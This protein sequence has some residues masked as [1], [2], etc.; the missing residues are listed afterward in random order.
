MKFTFK[1]GV[2][3]LASL[4]T[5]VAAINSSVRAEN[6]RVN[7]VPLPLAT[8]LDCN[9]VFIKEFTQVPVIKNSTQTT[10]PAGKVISWRGYW[11]GK[12]AGGNK[13]ITLTQPLA[14][15]Q[16]INT[17]VQLSGDQNSCKAYY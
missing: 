10:I 2:I 12:P 7:K 5:S 17:G 3:V 9:A 13:S 6:I 1:T 16:T 4:L 15:G 8:S 14:P 11:A